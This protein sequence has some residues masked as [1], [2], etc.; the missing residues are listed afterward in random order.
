MFAK[1]AHS[2]FP[3]RL[4]AVLTGALL[5]TGAI[6]PIIAHAEDTFECYNGGLTTKAQA[7]AYGAVNSTWA[8]YFDTARSRWA[9]AGVGASFAKI[10]FATSSIT[11]GRY[12]DS[13]F[14]IY[15]PHGSYY[16]IK[17][18]IRS[19]DAKT[20][21]A[22]TFALWSK[23]TSTHE[24]GHALRLPD[25]PPTTKTSL[26]SHSR[27]RSKVGSPT[28][29]DK[30]NVKYCLG[31]LPTRTGSTVGATE[32]MS[33][34]YPTYDSLADA[35]SA[36]DVV[37]RASLVRSVASVLMPD[38]S[39]N[40][41]DARTNPQYGVRPTAKDL[42]DLRVPVTVST[43]Q[44]SETLKG[45]L[46]PGQDIK[47]SQLG[48]QLDGVQYREASTT[49]LANA[50]GDEYLLL[51]RMRNDGVYEMIGADSGWVVQRGRLTSLNGQSTNAPFGATSLPILSRAIDPAR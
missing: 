2:H 41:G 44:V 15:M 51:L 18:N 22:S 33:A 38:L 34:D 43:V 16:S 21:N 25:N 35:M 30:A 14:G 39:T 26:M 6:P 45:S 1:T 47:I 37:V 49:L 42:Q 40:T 7:V 23:S 48:G 3:R 12:S 17:V 10:S 11:A 28:A 8:A 4:I 36:A 24:L 29:Y 50:S 9:N 46:K 27:D 31:G 5:I 19:L 20:S 13:W 32:V